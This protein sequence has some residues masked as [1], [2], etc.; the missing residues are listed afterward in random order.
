M[1][2]RNS[3]SQIEVSTSKGWKIL[4]PRQTKIAEIHDCGDYCIIREDYLG[5]VGSNVYAIDD[6][7][8]L[9]WEAELPHPSDVF[10]NM[11]ISVDSGFET[12]TWNGIKCHIETKSGK[13]TQIGVTK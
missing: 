3:N 12:S 6:Q 4:K 1:K 10:A 11:L 2:Y 13:T 9:V 8:N 7:L 5:F